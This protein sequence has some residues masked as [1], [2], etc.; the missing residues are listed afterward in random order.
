MA[1]FAET[2]LQNRKKVESETVLKTNVSISTII[3][4]V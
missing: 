3:K 4:N 1:D 2:N